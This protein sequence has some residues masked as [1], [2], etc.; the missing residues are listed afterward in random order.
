MKISKRALLLSVMILLPYNLLAWGGVEK[1]SNGS[2]KFDLETGYKNSSLYIKDNESFLIV[3]GGDSR[4]GTI[5]TVYNALN[6]EEVTSGEKVESDFSGLMQRKGFIEIELNEKSIID[7]SFQNKITFLENSNEII[8]HIEPI[9]SSISQELETLI[10][11]VSD[12]SASSYINI[13]NSSKEFLS[14]PS[15]YTLL[16]DKLNSLSKANINYS[17]A[18]SLIDKLQEIN[19]NVN[20]SKGI[21]LAKQKELKAQIARIEK[22]T[23]DKFFDSSVKSIND[24]PQWM[25][26]MAQLGKKA[27]IPDYISQIMNLPDFGKKLNPSNFLTSIEYKYILK[28]LKLKSVQKITSSGNKYG[29]Y[30]EYPNK[31]IRL[32]LKPTCNLTGKTST[33]EFGCGFLW[34]NTCVGTYEEYKCKGNTS[35]IAQIEQQLLGTKKVATTL[36]K[37]WKYDHMI[38]KYTKQSSYTAPKYDYCGVND[39][40]YKLVRFKKSG[41]AI[42]KCTKGPS[43]GQEKCLSYNGKKYATGCGFSD[44]AAHHYTLEEAGNG[45]CEY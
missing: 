26:K 32:T 44:I 23:N 9:D 28:D 34:A 39:T 29:I 10:N 17:Y 4:Y 5:S 15:F 8:V 14:Y 40:C 33:S 22:E 18:L 2:C 20:S 41:S 42:V 35:K 6:C 13:S 11:K 38:S 16:F 43:T 24:V 36:N 19:I 31:D 27:L 21:L 30:L 3:D 25:N 7:K 45:A 12:M 1:L 37:G